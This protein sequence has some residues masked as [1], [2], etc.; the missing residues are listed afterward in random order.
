VRR[1]NRRREPQRESEQEIIEY[2]RGDVE[3]EALADC[4]KIR[5][6]IDIH[7]LHRLRTRNVGASRLGP[8]PIAHATN[9]AVWFVC[10]VGDVLAG[11]RVAASAPSKDV[12]KALGDVKR[13]LTA[14]L[15]LLDS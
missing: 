8:E 14:I 10:M 2:E 15:E 13:E 6:E 5:A 4:R 3:L 7:G 1:H 12:S 11:V 9:R